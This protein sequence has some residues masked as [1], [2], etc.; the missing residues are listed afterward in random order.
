M[1]VESSEK[2][3]DLIAIADDSGLA[4]ALVDENSYQV[5]AANNNS[6]CSALNPSNKFSPACQEYCGKAF[7][8]VKQARRP[9]EFECFAGLVC[10]AVPFREGRK[11][12]V[13]ITGRAFVKADSYRKATERAISGDWNKFRP[14]EFF[15]NILMTSSRQPIEKLAK[16]IS[17]LNATV[18]DDVLELRSLDSPAGVP[19]PVKFTQPEPSGISR[20][21]QKFQQQS[22]GE[23]H[24]PVFSAPSAEDDA[25]GEIADLRSLSSSLTKTN[26]EQAC[27]KL[28]VFVSEKYGI[29][30]LLWFEVHENGFKQVFTRGPIGK[31]A[32][33]VGVSPDHPAVLRALTSNMPLV[34]RERKRMDGTPQRTLNLYPLTVGGEVRSALGVEGDI[35]GGARRRRIARVAQS[36]AS[37]LEILRLRDEVTQ[38]DWLSRAIR[39]FNESLKK[40]DGED[41]WLRV[42]QVSA[43]LLG[44]ERAS[45]LVKNEKSNRL[46]A[47]AA[48]GSRIDL[49]S[50]KSVGTRVAFPALKNGRP[51]MIS[52][53]AAS[54]TPAPG[55]WRYKT[56]SFLSYPVSIGERKLA[57]LNF[58]DKVDGAVFN[59][60]DL[61]LLQAI[62]PQIAM[63][64]DRAS[65]K[66]KAGEFEQLS[67]TDSL[68]GLLNRRY[69]QERLN[70]EIQR[71]RRHRFA[72]SLLML[73]VD[74]FKSFNDTFGHLAGDAALRIVANILKQNLR[75]DD[76]AA[77]YGGEEFAVLLPQTGIDEASVIAERI[78]LQIERA[79]F[80]NR[81]I[82]A[83]IGIASWSANMNVPDD[84]IWAADRALYEAKEN[85]RNN[86][87]LYDDFGD[88]LTEKVH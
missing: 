68:T 65:L 43:E 7:D 46:Q 79:D 59:N 12:L 64:I 40:M 30:S 70:E 37:Q 22:P 72:L 27:R 51:V 71:S 16:T 41:F 66:L 38:R 85:G 11:P 58:T 33:D 9:V 31:K 62:S 24:P 36:I 32:V 1:L 73:D 26:Y 15:D 49:T 50:E 86:V 78:R 84:L 2:Y 53:V 19:G 29:D 63:A 28:L 3:E 81:R 10:R 35:F 8:K 88:P 55:E 77:R 39:V 52:D 67:V 6:I 83:S 23:P 34:L 82:T 21:I 61:E 5:A 76:V 13:A 54:G 74:N 14:T 48:V 60:R 18:N 69:L 80:P 17:G 75:G 47:K 42:T 4:I 56:A 57:V 44:A 20:L 45:L 87:Q 25:L